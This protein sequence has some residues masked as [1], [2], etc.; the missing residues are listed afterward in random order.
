MGCDSRRLAAESRASRICFRTNAVR[1]A[2]DRTMV[3]RR[4]KF[5]GQSK[6]TKVNGLA[7][8]VRRALVF[9][10]HQTKRA[11]T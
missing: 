10:Q 8:G 5:A 1:F 7:R 6:N 3:L 4:D 11:I 2:P 9:P